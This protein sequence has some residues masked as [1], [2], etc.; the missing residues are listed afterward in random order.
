MVASCAST[1]TDYLA[2]LPP[3]RRRVIAEVRKLANQHLPECYVEAMG[4]DMITGQIPRSRYS[5]TCNKQPL[6]P[7][8]LAA[9]KNH[10]AL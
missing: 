8:A 2:Q 10:F 7:V 6:A 9:Q 1:V 3:A 4:L 5:D